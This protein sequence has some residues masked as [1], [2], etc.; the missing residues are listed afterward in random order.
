LPSG[1]PPIAAEIHA[2]QI[3]LIPMAAAAA[4]NKAR[5]SAHASGT[6]DA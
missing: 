4:S 6:P 5:R 2:K 3:Q 1:R